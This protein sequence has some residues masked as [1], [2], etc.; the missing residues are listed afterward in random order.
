MIF[1]LSTSANIHLQI[2]REECSVFYSTF[3]MVLVPELVS[4]LR[5]HAQL[6][7]S[8]ILLSSSLSLILQLQSQISRVLCVCVCATNR[9]NT[10]Y[11]LELTEPKAKHVAQRGLRVQAQKS[12][13][14]SSPGP[15]ILLDMPSVATVARFTMPLAR[16]F[17]FSGHSAGPLQLHPFLGLPC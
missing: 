16:H 4:L 12:E 8:S 1:F 17:P 15:A 2:R 7:L 14:K 3:A 10:A 5:M 9:H 11:Q 13:L 6:M